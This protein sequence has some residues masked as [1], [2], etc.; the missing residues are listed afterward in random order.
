MMQRKEF[1]K[2]CGFACLGLTGASF[3]LDSCTPTRYVQSGLEN[4]YLTLSAAEFIIKKDNHI[5][6]RSY[7]ILRNEKMDFP[8][9]LYRFNEN[10]YHAVLLKCTHQGTELTVNGD[11]L[12]CSA[13]GSEFSNQGEVITGPADTNLTSYPVVVENDLIKIK[14]T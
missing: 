8:I 5:K 12:T 13:H 1:I 3:L 9:F 2:T 4:N 10:K 11:M 14:I 7:V 6:Y